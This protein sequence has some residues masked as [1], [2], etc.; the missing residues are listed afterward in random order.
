MNRRGATA[1][2]HLGPFDAGRIQRLRGDVADA[3][4][5]SQCGEAQGLALPV[6]EPLRRKP[7]EALMRQ[8]LAVATIVLAL[9]DGRV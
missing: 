7:A 4:G 3:A 6:I 9:D 1:Q 2:E 8:R 5:R